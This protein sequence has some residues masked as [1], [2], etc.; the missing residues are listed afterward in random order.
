MADDITVVRM[1][2]SYYGF[3]VKFSHPV[4]LWYLPHLDPCEEWWATDEQDEHL[5]TDELGA[6]LWGLEVIKKHKEMENGKRP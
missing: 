3:R 2:K 5:G 1:E 4:R 6:Y